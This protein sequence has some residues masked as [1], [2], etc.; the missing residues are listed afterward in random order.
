MS[1]IRCSVQLDQMLSGIAC[2]LTFMMILSVTQSYT[3]TVEKNRYA[4]ISP[5]SERC[6][7]SNSSLGDTIVCSGIEIGDNLTALIE[8][9]VD[10]F[11]NDDRIVGVLSIFRILTENRKLSENWIQTTAFRVKRLIFE[12]PNIDDI[13][14]N[15]FRG[16][17]FEELIALDIASLTIEV[18]NEGIFEG[19]QYLE[20]LTISQC[21]IHQIFANALRPMAASLTMISFESL[22]LPLDVTNLT[23]TVPLPKVTYVDFR[24][25]DVGKLN[26][27]SFSQ[28]ENSETVFLQYSLIE[29]IDC[30]TF[31]NMTGLNTLVL[32]GTLLTTLDSCV[33]GDELINRMQ[34]DTLYLGT[35]NWNCNCDLDWLKQL[36]LNYVV[37]DTPRCYSHSCLP[38]E[39]VEFCP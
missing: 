39:E 31:E 23:G 19:L 18:L 30:G 36:K 28:I 8:E 12:A 32:M 38:F 29:D 17:I 27:Q 15:A 11:E 37:G 14:N 34:N 21:R 33:F 9:E 16:Y 1:N 7:T 20:E 35:N 25:N 13:E 24:Y 10:N 2:L 3:M 4:E 6:S 5:L 22:I 26:A